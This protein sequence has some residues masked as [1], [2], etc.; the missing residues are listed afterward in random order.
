MIYPTLKMPKNP[1]SFRFITTPLSS[2]TQ[3]FELFAFELLNSIS[4]NKPISLFSQ[5]I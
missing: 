5:N 2:I 3:A 4:Q 1:T